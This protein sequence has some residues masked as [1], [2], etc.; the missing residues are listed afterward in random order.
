MGMARYLIP[1]PANASVGRAML[2]RTK[3]RAFSGKAHPGPSI[4]SPFAIHDD[5][6][7]GIA[8]VHRVPFTST[9]GIRYLPKPE[10]V[11]HW[12]FC[13]RIGE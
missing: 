2:I 12:L 4:L 1:P 6:L 7:D 3:S 8:E 9:L 11:G 10:P 13:W 5:D